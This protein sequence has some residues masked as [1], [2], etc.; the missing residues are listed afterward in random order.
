MFYEFDLLYIRRCSAASRAKRSIEQ[1]DTEEALDF[2]EEKTHHRVRRQTPTGSSDVSISGGKR[3]SKNDSDI[4]DVIDS[5]WRKVRVE[6]PVGQQRLVI[7]A[8]HSY[9]SSGNIYLES[10]ELSETTC[11]VSYGEKYVYMVYG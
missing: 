8:A 9:G 11:G 3:V 2:A 7:S 1:L 5:A 4:H 10:I 6:I